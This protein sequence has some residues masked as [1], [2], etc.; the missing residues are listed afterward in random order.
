[1]SQAYRL[2]GIKDQMLYISE[3]LDGIWLLESRINEIVTKSKM[4]DE[5]TGPLK[6]MSPRE[7]MVWVEFLEDKITT[8]SDF[9]Y[10]NPW[11][12]RTSK[13]SNC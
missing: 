12:F 13:F 9:E 11:L 3:V 5:M 6:A 4:I 10:W 7:L 1:M 2:V 8:T